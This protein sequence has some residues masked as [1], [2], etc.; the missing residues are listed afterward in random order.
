MNAIEVASP[1]RR[2][3]QPIIVRAAEI[4][5]SYG[6]PV[7][8]RQLYYRLVAERALE[9][10][11][12]DYNRL[13]KLTAQGRRDGTFPGL[14]DRGRQVD[15]WLTFSGP[16]EARRWLAQR[17]MRDRTEGQ[18]WAVYLGVEKATLLGQLE[19][20]FGA[21][22]IPRVALRGYSSQT[23]VDEVANQVAADVTGDVER[24]G[25]PAVLIYCGDYDPSG[26]DILRD[27][28]ERTHCFE[29]VVQVAVTPDQIVSMGLIGA[30]AKSGDSRGRGT[31]VKVQVEVE[32]IPPDQL[33]GLLRTVVTKWWDDA[34]YQAVLEREREERE[35]L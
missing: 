34:A 1:G 3:W 17:Y 19:A 6:T 5:R 11:Q 20:W 32:A 13:A 4:V 28:A 21:Y 9:N 24:Q 27:F 18:P 8:L 33:E 30:P 23:L 2:D 15:R 25:R 16:G 26:V 14:I 12:N 31:G 35:T 10:R 7:T 29:E 22:G